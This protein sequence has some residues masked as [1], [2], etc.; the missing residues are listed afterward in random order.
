MPVRS[1][2]SLLAALLPLLLLI[3][4][5]N[6]TDANG[7]GVADERA[8]TVVYLTRHAEKAAGEDPGLLPAGEARAARLARRLQDENLTAVYATGYRRTQATAAP[9]AKAA[10][11]T[12]REYEA[13]GAA[14]AQTKAWL[15]RHR[16]GTILVVGHSN[17]VPDLLNALVGRRRYGNIDEAEYG[18]LFRVTVP[19]KGKARV[20]ELSSD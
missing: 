20:E 12:V 14:A 7:T 10:G 15:T 2:L 16:G 5:C 19:A 17:T 4:A 3:A 6:N 9:A 1:P 8:T 11:L 18:R 13:G